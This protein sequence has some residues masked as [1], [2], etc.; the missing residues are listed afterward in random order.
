M[1][2]LGGVGAGTKVFSTL[3]TKPVP[4]PSFG[5]SR[6]VA[7][8]ASPLVAGMA[9]LDAPAELVIIFKLIALQA[10]A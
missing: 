4:T 5:L 9:T 3:D 6:P 7:T 1:G 2:G 10:G 8:A